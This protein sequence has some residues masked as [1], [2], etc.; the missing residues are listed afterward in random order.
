MRYIPSP[1][2]SNSHSH[3][4]TLIV[5]FPSHSHSPRLTLIVKAKVIPIVICERSSSVACHAVPDRQ[6]YYLNSN[7]IKL[8]LLST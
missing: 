1:S 2:H 6:S 5:F 4:P 3:R 7:I 8:S